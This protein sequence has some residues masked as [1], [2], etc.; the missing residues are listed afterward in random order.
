MVQV[1]TDPGGWDSVHPGCRLPD[2]VRSDVYP[3]RTGAFW[4]CNPR[5]KRSSGVFG[6]TCHKDPA[7]R[8]GRQ[9]RMKLTDDS[10]QV[11]VYFEPLTR[12]VAISSFVERDFA[13]EC[14]EAFLVLVPGARDFP[15]WR[16]TCTPTKL[17]TRKLYEYDIQFLRDFGA[18]RWHRAPV[19]FPPRDGPYSDEY[20]V[21]AL[22]EPLES[23]AEL[24]Y[25]FD[26]LV[27]E[28]NGF[29]PDA[30]VDVRYA[31]EDGGQSERML[32]SRY[33]EPNTTDVSAEADGANLAAS[34]LGASPNKA[35]NTGELS[36]TGHDPQDELRTGLLALTPRQSELWDALAG[37][38]K[39][40]DSLARQLT[41]KPQGIKQLVQGIRNKLGKSSVA[42]RN[43]F[44]YYRP[45][46]PPNWN[47]VKPRKRRQ[48]RPK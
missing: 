5:S 33:A 42:V 28:I 3:V 2:G 18:N 14:L 36:T 19:F 38:C 9:V 22:G 44:G 4:C 21:D 46:A 7:R 39:D 34:V 20:L 8:P 37:H 12:R 26:R 32:D 13:R 17:V 1:G 10:W 30:P 47:E 40:G 27:D 43:G 23:L 11:T 15:E 6:F 45:D 41:N 31:S 25:R 48:V 29:D 24:A 16:V 35:A